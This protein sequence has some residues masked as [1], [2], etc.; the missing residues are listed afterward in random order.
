ME[1]ARLV[2]V[3]AKNARRYLPARVAVD[4]RRVN[5]EIARHVFGQTPRWVRHVMSLI[6]QM[7]RTKLLIS[8][9]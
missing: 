9:E 7:Q 4:A 1:D 3:I 6:S 5:V 8:D 2:S